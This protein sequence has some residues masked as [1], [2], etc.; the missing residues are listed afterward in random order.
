MNQRAKGDE[1]AAASGNIC[2]ISGFVLPVL[3]N[4]TRDV[5][6]MALLTALLA[7]IAVYRATRYKYMF[8]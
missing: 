1:G 7:A 3:G 8:T 5:S 4:L 2:N 6:G